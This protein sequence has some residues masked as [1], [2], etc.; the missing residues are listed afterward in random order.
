MTGG[1]PKAAG[2]AKGAKAA[3][4]ALVPAGLVARTAYDPNTQEPNSTNLFT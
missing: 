4:G 2:S 1:P 3:A